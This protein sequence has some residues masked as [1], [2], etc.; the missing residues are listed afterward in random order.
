MEAFPEGMHLRLRNRATNQYLH[1]DKDGTSVSLRGSWSRA[2]LSTE[3][4]AHRHEHDGTTYVRLHSAANGR[5]LA[6]KFKR[7]RHGLRNRFVHV[8]PCESTEVVDAFT[9]W[10]IFRATE[11][12]EDV[13][14]RH[15]SNSVLAAIASRWPGVAALDYDDQSPPVMHWVVAEAIPP[16]PRPQ[17]LPG[18]SKAIE[19]GALIKTPWY[20]KC[21]EKATSDGQ[22]VCTSCAVY[23]RKLLNASKTEMNIPNSYCLVCHQLGA[24]EHSLHRRRTILIDH[25]EKM[26]AAYVTGKEPWAGIFQGIQSDFFG[27]ILLHKP[28]GTRSTVCNDLLEPAGQELYKAPYHFCSLKCFVENAGGAAAMQLAEKILEIDFESSASAFCLVCEIA[29]NFHED[30]GH[31]THKWIHIISD[32][33]HRPRVQVSARHQLPDEWHNI[34][35]RSVGDAETVELLIQDR[36]SVRCQHCKMRLVDGSKKYCTLECSLDWQH[37]HR[38][39]P[40]LLQLKG[41]S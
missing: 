4:V 8:R 13:L 6:A 11:G 35:I 41:I 9:L 22:P 14:M 24:E 15:V 28:E 19:Q 39:V 21:C 29:F 12:G 10:E 20:C 2:L 17:V 7:S 40:R 16:R 36:I 5:Y 34:K 37:H 38:L 31:A 1:V 32:S 3:W 30:N 33:G 25:L 18:P 23:L 27:F 26:P